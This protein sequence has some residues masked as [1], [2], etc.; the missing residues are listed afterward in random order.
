MTKVLKIMVPGILLLTA[1]LSPALAS[2][3]EVVV[4]GTTTQVTSGTPFTLYFDVTNK[5]STPISFNRVLVGYV[6]P[7]LTMH[8]PYPKALSGTVNPNEKK[9]FSC[10]LTI[11]IPNDMESGIVVPVVVSLFSG[12]YNQP[13]ARGGGWGGFKVV[14]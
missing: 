10:S 11:T 1:L 4:V 5:H 14:Y 7:N 9:R 3:L 12:G 2:S 6:L 13:S 8:G